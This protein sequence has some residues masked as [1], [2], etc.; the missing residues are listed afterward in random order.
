MR[1]ADHGGVFCRSRFQGRTDARAPRFSDRR[2]RR[3]WRRHDHQG[4]ARWRPC[5]GGHVQGATVVRDP[6]SLPISAARCSRRLHAGSRGG[7]GAGS[8]TGERRPWDIADR[9]VEGDRGLRG[10][11]YRRGA[12]FVWR[13]G[14]AR[15]G[16]T[17]A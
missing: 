4:R 12:D 6:R 16:E 10:W 14:R 2:G 1:W 17:G 15:A 3:R 13:S 11:V 8:G 9:D 5:D 7:R